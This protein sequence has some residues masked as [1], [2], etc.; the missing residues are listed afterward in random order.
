[1]KKKPGK[2]VL[3]VELTKG[4]NDMMTWVIDSDRFQWV[5]YGYIVL[6]DSTDLSQPVKVWGPSPEACVAYTLD[7][8]A[9]FKSS[10]VLDIVEDHNDKAPSSPA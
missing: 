3:G 2:I 5:G 7:L 4:S 1:M 9:D 8:V 6:H 10:D